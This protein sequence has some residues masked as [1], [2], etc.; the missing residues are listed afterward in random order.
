[1]PNEKPTKQMLVGR[2]CDVSGDADQLRSHAR[3]IPTRLLYCQRGDR[4]TT[5]AECAAIKHGVRFL[6]PGNFSDSTITDPGRSTILMMHGDLKAV[7]QTRKK[8]AGSKEKSLAA[9]D[10]FPTLWPN[11][12]YASANQHPGKHTLC[13]R[14]D[15]PSLVL[16]L[17]PAL[18]LI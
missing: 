18:T 14:A 11:T 4:V 7:K 16:S 10:S 9:L 1:V 13:L 6:N 12:K 15:A 5:T 17:M 8:F 2:D 3:G